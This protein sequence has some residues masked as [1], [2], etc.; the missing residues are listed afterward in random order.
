MPKYLVAL[1]FSLTL[2]FAKNPLP[3]AQLGDDIYNSLESYKQ[4]AISLDQMDSTVTSYI[5]M[6]Q[7]TKKLGYR[8]EISPELSKSYLVGLRVCDKERQIIATQLNTLLYR[9]MDNKD[10]K[11]F[12]KLIDSTFINLD[13]VSDDAI[14]FYKHYF[15]SGS[16]EKLDTLL[17]SEKRYKSDKKKANTE[18]AKYVEKKRIQRMRDASEKAD[19]SREAELD[20]DIEMQRREINIMMENELIR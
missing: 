3:Y 11:I 8:A 18:Y 17:Q 4:L 13:K 5:N 15:K 14:P 19:T 7:E 16:I 20:K 9:A 10:T 12:K 2:L 1:L 6:V